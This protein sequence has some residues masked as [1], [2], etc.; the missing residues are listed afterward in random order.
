MSYWDVLKN[1]KISDGTDTRHYGCSL[2]LYYVGDRPVIVIGRD[3]PFSVVMWALMI[4]YYFGQ[5]KYM[6]HTPGYPVL[7]DISFQIIRIV[8]FITCFLTT[9]INSGV[10]SFRSFEDFSRNYKIGARNIRE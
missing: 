1:W 3:W 2:P 6:Y 10:F 8:H 7:S 9:F 5:F 4:Y